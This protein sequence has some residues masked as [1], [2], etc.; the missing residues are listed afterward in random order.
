[1]YECYI[2]IHHMCLCAYLEEP[3]DCDALERM[4]IPETTD[5]DQ[6]KAVGI[7]KIEDN[8]GKDRFL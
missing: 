7:D 2:M 3:V 1:M 4:C 8:E 6:L 5:L